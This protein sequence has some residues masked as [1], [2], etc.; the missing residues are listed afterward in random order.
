MHWMIPFATPDSAGARAILPQLQLPHLQRLL[1]SLVAQPKQGG[2]A[3]SLSPPHEIA[4]ARA[5]GWPVQD[6]LLPWAAWQAQR[7]GVADA[8]T[9]GW[10]FITLC[11]WTVQPDHMVMGPLPLPGLTDAHSDALLADMRPYFQEDGITLYPDQTGRWLAQA[12]WL[13]TLASASPDRVHARNLQHWLPDAKDAGPLLRL[14]NE[15]QM[16]LYTHP[17]NAEREAQGLPAINSFW[18]SGTGVLPVNG[19]APAG[20]AVQLI[21]TLRQPAL[22]ENWPAWQQAWQTL[23]ANELRQAVQTL[24]QG[25]PVTLTLCG[26]HASQCWQSAP[27]SL[28]QRLHRNWRPRPFHQWLE[29]L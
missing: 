18:I 17:I 2:D 12:P 23:D 9:T 7:N 6:G 11:H 14:Q 19:A 27:L 26:E 3:L 4:L 16:L 1:A 20:P 8:S 15:M 22:D 25:Q 28:W 10:G 5:L 13:A 29:A 21:D 24:Q